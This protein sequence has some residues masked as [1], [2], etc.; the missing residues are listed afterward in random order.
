MRGRRSVIVAVALVLGIVAGGASYAFLHSVQQRAYN[1]AKL[2]DVYVAN[3]PIGQGIT[4]AAAVGGGLIKKTQIPA[5]FEPAGAVTD[6]AAIQNEVATSNIPAGQV[7][8]GGLFASPS[9]TAGTAAQDIPK[10]DVAIT[11]SVDPV[12]GV[13]GLIQP[14]DQVDVLVTAANAETYLYQNV[15]VLAVGTALVN[16]SQATV[17][18]AQT[19]AAAPAPAPSSNLIT[20]AVPPDAAARIA[21]AQSG[22]GSGG[23]GGNNL[24]LA[25][26]PPGS[27]PSAVPPAINAAN[28]IPANRIPG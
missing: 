4:G 15:P 7:V 10:G 24:Y 26:V 22:S 27:A 25:L 9:T 16:R 11:V 2:T 6:L 12:H 3:A 17:T 1:G 21:F 8:V 20:F 28:L 5:K 18:A 14:G 19:P 23:S 13:A